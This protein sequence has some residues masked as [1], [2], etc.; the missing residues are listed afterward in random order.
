M[1][2]HGAACA[3]HR[4]ALL[5]FID[6]REVGPDTD[7]ALD[8]LGRCRACERE[9][10]TTAMAVAALRRLHRETQEVE[11]PPDAWVRLLER[12]DRPREAVWRWWTTLA[13][14]AV[15]AGLVATILA[16]ASVWEQRATRLQEPGAAAAAYD[17]LRL[18]EHRA[19]SLVLDQQRIVRS[20]PP[21]A[22]AGPAGVAP[23]AADAGW[24]GPDGLGITTRAPVGDPPIGRS[25]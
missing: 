9:L 22:T 1:S 10:E 11:P 25:R 24:I 15:G 5:D 23:S 12:V 2:E 4:D 3:A 18:A 6:R 16:P 13:G 7:A 20:G 21:P 19:E 14:L 17:T 8:H